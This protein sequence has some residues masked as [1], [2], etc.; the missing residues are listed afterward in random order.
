M[1][2]CPRAGGIKILVKR[3]NKNGREEEAGNEDADRTGG[4]GRENVIGMCLD[5]CH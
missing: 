2:T 5:M 4:G 3:E 1:I